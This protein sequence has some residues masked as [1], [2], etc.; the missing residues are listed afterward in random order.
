MGLGTP[1]TVVN[2]L[3]LA[4]A[5]WLGFYV[6]TRSPKSRVAWLAA[7]TLWS[8]A[9]LFLHNVIAVNLPES[10]LSARLRPVIVLA[11]PLWFH[12]TFRLSPE[13]TRWWLWT[14]SPA[15]SRLV[16]GLAYG[17][18]LAVIAG[19]VVPG[20]LSPGAEI[21]TAARLSGRASGRLYP[22][23]ILFLLVWGALSFVNL[24]QGRA[25]TRDSGLRRRFAPLLAATLLAHLG[26][27]YI[28][29]GVWLRLDW[30]T[31]PGDGALGVGVV[32]LGYAVARY[33]AL[34]QARALRRD[35][36]YATLAVGL[37]TLFYY[38]VAL[39]L[40]HSG[41]V[42]FLSLMLVIAV[43]ISSHALYDGVRAGLDRFFYQAQF[44]QLR[45]NLRALA[46][47]AGGGQ[48]LPE[49]L[50]AILGALC[51]ALDIEA[52]FI[53][54]L[55]GDDLVVAAARQS[56]EVGQAIPALPAGET[57]TLP[58]P[59][60]PGLEGMRLLV[61]LYAGGAQVGVLALG[62]KASGQPYDGADL[63]LLEDLADQMAAVI[64]TARLQEENA[65]AINQMVADF[66]ARE[67]RLQR[68]VQR[69]VAERAERSGPALEGVSDEAFI[70]LVE[71]GLRRLHDFPYLGE[72]ALARL[73]IVDQRL[74]KREA[75]FVT[76]LDRGRAL[77]QV[78]LQA[79]HKL[80]PPGEEPPSHQV[81]P[82]EWHQYIILHD[83]YAL[84]ELNRDIMGRLYIGEGTF[85]R[86]RRRA[87][88]GVAKAL[89][90][91]EEEVK[92]RDA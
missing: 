85:N 67:Q 62:P 91:M 10:G 19:G 2:L 89:Q 48:P 64:Y 31:L 50:Q 8:I 33:N 56:R 46:Q 43:A 77:N 84:G 15:V 87:V 5:L 25:R 78:L 59:A 39:A 52:G 92:R 58:Q 49:Q 69:L 70:S 35:F 63:E 73:Q 79:L 16:I 82:R 65:R 22:L 47:E 13:E 76:H 24:W 41:H 60:P 45:A 37:L 18:A 26:I 72:Q 23:A 42:S 11:L 38:L 54:L 7:L 80:R 86:A 12:L 17:S 9:S 83:A 81:P 71:D 90:E 75:E 74:E 57:T 32:L 27:L 51:R 1:T 53:G 34:V 14:R 3:A 28:M 44:R 4:A 66:R 68:Q 21:G 88:R 40:Y 55:Q 36:A 29:L 20:T 6:V 30:P 61:P